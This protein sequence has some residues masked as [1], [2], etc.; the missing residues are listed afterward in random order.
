MAKPSS[1][2]PERALS[3]PRMAIAFGYLAFASSVGFVTGALT[4]CRFFYNYLQDNFVDWNIHRIWMPCVSESVLTVALLFLLAPLAVLLRRESFDFTLAGVLG[5]FASFSLL[6]TLGI[7]A[8]WA[9]LPLSL[10]ISVQLARS[11]QQ[12]S[13]RI[14]RRCQFA[15]PAGVVLIALTAVTLI[16][17]RARQEQAALA[18]LGS[19]SQTAPNVLLVVWD[20]VRADYVETFDEEGAP[21]PNL[22]R[23]AERGV[24]FERAISAASWTLPSHTSMFTG[25]FPNEFSADWFTPIDQRQTMLAEVLR[26]HGYQTGGFVSNTRYCGRGVGMDQ[27]FVHYEDFK[28]TPR[29]IGDCNFFY[30]LAKRKWPQ[31]SPTKPGKEITNDFIR[32]FQDIERDRPFFAFL[33]YMDAHTPYLPE[34]IDGRPMTAEEVARMQ[35]FESMDPEGIS[36]A[37]R[38]LA[39]KCYRAQI[40]ALDAQLGRLIELLSR[41]EVLDDTVVIV[42]SDHGEHFGEHGLYYHGNSV[43]KPVVHVPLVMSLPGIIPEGLRV[44]GSISLRNIGATILDCAEIRESTPIRGQS[45]AKLA[46]QIKGGDSDAQS[47]NDLVYAYNSLKSVKSHDTNPLLL[48]KKSIGWKGRMDLWVEGSFFLV[49]KPEGE[50]ELYNVVSDPQENNNLSLHAEKAPVLTRMQKQIEEFLDGRARPEV[51]ISPGIAPSRKTLDK[52]Q[53]HRSAGD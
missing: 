52:P 34:T 25:Q 20:T 51:H 4:A 22:N 49:R 10:G 21:T 1:S 2:A 26:D 27:G 29:E 19:A 35:M 24:V 38:E 53:S 23:L 44:D 11:F 8:I 43:Y 47:G 14:Q 41:R 6:S 33:N 30:R 7:L 18:D 48:F 40:T 46:D 32:W 17:G 31:L 36:D 3:P 45:L 37:D 13:E 39:Q 12:H 28:V 15:A 50:A 5:F 42:L 16:G 9:I